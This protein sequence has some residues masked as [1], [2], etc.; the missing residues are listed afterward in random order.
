MTKVAT[1]FDFEL[2]TIAL[3]ANVLTNMVQ[4]IAK[5]F[6]SIAEKVTSMFAVTKELPELTFSF[7]KEQKFVIENMHNVQY[8]DM[9]DQKVFVPENFTGNIVEYGKLLEVL[10]NKHRKSATDGLQN[11]NV[12]LSQFISNKD[13]KLSTVDA[14]E[15]YYKMHK[16]RDD[17][18]SSLVSFTSDN[19]QTSFPLGKIISRKDDLRILFDNK[20]SIQR[21]IENVDLKELNAGVKKCVDLIDLVVDQIEKGLITNVTPESTK[22]LAYGASEVA[23][24]IEFF[25]VLYF[26]VIGYITCV[27]SIS[28][29]SNN[30]L[31]NIH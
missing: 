26:R 11:F 10:I 19:S 30:F 23:K 9:A 29:S 16:E 5:V 21:Q 6:P 3:E 7:S 28:L 8:L 17:S 1:N 4:T 27:D 25:A 2:R 22:N 15:V 18:V 31:K 14:T 20:G 12:Y 13:A 24:E